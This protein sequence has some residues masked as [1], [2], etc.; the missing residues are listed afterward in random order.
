M[1]AREGRVGGSSCRGSLILALLFAFAGASDAFGSPPA[2]QIALDVNY[3]EGTFRGELTLTYENHS[4]APLEEIFFRLCANARSLYGWASLDVG[5]AHADGES[6]LVS[7]FVDNTVLLVPLG[8]PLAPGASAEIT[9]SF[10]GRAATAPPEGGFSSETEYGLLLKSSHTLT[11]TAFYPS[12]APYTEEG[13]AIDPVSALGDALFADSAT[14][15]VTLRVESEVT[16]IPTADEVM[17]EPDG[18]TLH[19]FHRGA[20][21]DFPLVLVDDGRQPLVTTAD[22][23]T[24][25]SWFSPQHAQAADIALQ[26]GGA[27]IEVF[28]SRFGALPYETVDIVEVPLQ[29][30]AGV[31]CSGLFLVS[32]AYAARPRDVFFDIIVSHEMAH[33]WFYAVVGNDPTEEPW[34]DE[35]LA[36]YAS[37]IFLAVISPTAAQSERSTWA[38]LYDRTRRDY[39][40]LR[41]TSPLYDFPDSATYSAFV[42]SGGALELDAIRRDVGDQLFFQGLAEYYADHALGIASGAD[43]FASL[44]R[45]CACPLSSALFGS[46]SATGP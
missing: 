32:A 2:Y 1:G 16:V 6:V 18:R 37:N 28:S 22:G 8:R 39:P 21:R 33:Q 7:L 29:R 36:T 34:L 9:L 12:V 23:I 14:Y 42:Y 43:L 25:R 31:E 11:L 5:E 40:D 38:A 26:R 3:A 4:N 45:A 27:A 24:L 35:A 30:V 10:L 41:V 17:V 44:S 20:L 15:D 13:W 46:Q 19:S